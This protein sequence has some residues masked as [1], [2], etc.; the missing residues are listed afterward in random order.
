MVSP[1]SSSVSSSGRILIQSVVCP[2]VNRRLSVD[3]DDQASNSERLAPFSGVSVNRMWTGPSPSSGASARVTVI[4]TV[5]ALL[6]HVGSSV[7]GHLDLARRYA[8]LRLD[9]SGGHALQ[10]RG[11]CRSSS[12]RGHLDPDPLALVVGRQGV[13][14][15]PSAPVDVR[16]TRRRQAV[17]TGRCSPG[18]SAR[19]GRR[20]RR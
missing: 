8:G 20:C 3:D 1:S 15:L 10:G 7:Q 4:W 17:A 9:Q 18:W 12:L 5:L 14:H 13:D 16:C 6:D 19:L 2:A 11:R